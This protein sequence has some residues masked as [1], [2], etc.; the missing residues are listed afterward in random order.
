MYLNAFVVFR[1]RPHSTGPR[2]VFR[3]SRRPH[4][5]PATPGRRHTEKEIPIGSENAILN[6]LRIGSVDLVDI[7]TRISGNGSFNGNQLGDN[8]WVHWLGGVVP[9]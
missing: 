6:G 2:A 3:F 7:F 8:T 4:S 9:T 5:P 1:S